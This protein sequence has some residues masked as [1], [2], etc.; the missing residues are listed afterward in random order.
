VED[1]IDFQSF[2]N[3]ALLCSKYDP[4]TGSKYDPMTG[5]LSRVFLILSSNQLKITSTIMDTANLIP[6]PSPGQASK[7]SIFDIFLRARPKKEK[8]PNNI[9]IRVNLNVPMNANFEIMDN[10][11]IHGVLPTIILPPFSQGQAQCHLDM[12]HMACLKLVQK[13]EDMN[14]AQQQKVLSLKYVVQKSHL[15][16]LAQNKVLFVKHYIRKKVK[17]TVSKLPTDG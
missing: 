12:S 17:D 11:R 7:C 9:L 14:G 8:A 13:G 6:Q 2:F 4:M 16:E 15:S 10:S 5:N 1:M 3:I